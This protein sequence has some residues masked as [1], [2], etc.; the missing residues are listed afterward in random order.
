[1]E[2]QQIEERYEELTKLYPNKTFPLTANPSMNTKINT[3]KIKNIFEELTKYGN[4]SVDQ[5]IALTKHNSFITWI[6]SIT[7]SKLFA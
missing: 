1:M 2:K 4:M 6:T 5:L 3:K 7:P